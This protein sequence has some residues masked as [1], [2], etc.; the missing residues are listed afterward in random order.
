VGFVVLF[1]D[2]SFSLPSA[3]LHLVHYTDAGEGAGIADAEERAGGSDA[4]NANS[5][6]NN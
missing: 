5:S 4:T 6:N 3:F 1:S 2:L